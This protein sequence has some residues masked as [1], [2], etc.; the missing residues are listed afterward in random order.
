MVYRLILDE[1]VEHEVFH[2]LDN[3]GHDVKHV[4]FVAELGKGAGDHPIAQ[5]SLDTERVIVTYDD[6]FVLEVDDGTYRTVLYFDD[7]TLSVEQVADV[8]HA[9]SQHYPQTELQGLE[10]VGEKW[11]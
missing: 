3:Y 7:A 8:V 5:Y 6:D 9:V 10:Y 4:D 2:R 11:L 1:N